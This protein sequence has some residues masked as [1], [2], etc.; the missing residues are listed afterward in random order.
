V[1][2]RL[3]RVVL[4]HRVAV[5][6]AWAVVLLVSLPAMAKLSSLL[7]NR[8]SLPGTDTHRAELILEDHFG[9]TSTGSFTLVVRGPPGSAERLAP[10]V[11]RAAS[12]MASGLP[13]GKLAG[14]Q[15]VSDSV[16]TATIVSSL[17]AADAKRHTDELREAAGRVPGALETYVT[18]QAAIE[19]DLDPVFSHDL[20]I[21][22]FLVAVPVALAILVFVFGTAA[23]LGPFVIAL[24]S[25]PATLAI[26]WIVANFMEL[27]T[28]L[29]N[30]VMLIGLG[31]AID[32]SLFVV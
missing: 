27:T 24:V 22:E 16:V 29:Q 12:R 30:M 6:V 15:P 1:I 10:A 23:F 7:T 28:Y 25:I 19:H 17:Q 32:Y 5:V 14:V 31:I 9:Q 2:G 20:K 4:R 3:T 26:I 18:G 11:E 13:T 8:F 21:G